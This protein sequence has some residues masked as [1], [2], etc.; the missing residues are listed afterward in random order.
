MRRDGN[1]DRDIEVQQEQGD[2]SDRLH[3]LSR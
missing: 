1:A 2:M 3:A